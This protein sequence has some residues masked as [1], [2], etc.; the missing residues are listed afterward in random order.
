LS[1][2]LAE[3][4]MNRRFGLFLVL[5]L[6]VLSVT[7]TACLG[8]LPQ[9][10]AP[11]PEKAAGAV[12]TAPVITPTQ[13]VTATKQLTPTIAAGKATTVTTASVVSATVGVTTTARVTATTSVTVTTSMTA[14]PVSPAKPSAPVTDIMPLKLQDITFLLETYGKPANPVK[15]LPETRI[16][17]R[18]GADGKVVGKAG[19]NNYNA[20][21]V[22]TGAELS[23]GP[24]AA[25]RMICTK[26]VMLQEQAYLDALVAARTYQISSG[27]KL[28]IAYAEGGVL[29]FGVQAAAAN[30]PTISV[31]ATQAVTATGAISVT[32]QATPRAMPQP[33]RIEFPKGA[34]SDK[35]E[36]Y[37]EPGT[38]IL[39]VLRAAAGQTMTVAPTAAKGSVQVSILGADRKPLGTV[40][41]PQKWSGILPASQD[42]YLTV[43]V[44][45][46]GAATNY[47]LAI[48][49]VG[50]PGAPTSPENEPTA[51][52]FD[53]G[54][55]TT[56][57]SGQVKPGGS[58]NYTLD[59]KA[60]QKLIVGVNAN[61]P[62]RVAI[63]DPQGQLVGVA[64]A[65]A[66][67]SGVLP[68]TGEYRLVVQAPM[69]IAMVSYTLE[70]TLK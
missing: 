10:P 21:Y 29:T 1:E 67:W 35:I 61:G 11:A 17:A 68:V 70:I 20:T 66:P 7:L 47:T 53:V 62:M 58:V 42:Y 23:V 55:T 50:K 38:P 19:C 51:I 43:S 22:A 56:Q 49:I 15:V 54:A 41:S 31:T 65:K 4:F 52:R 6:L 2:T 16:T 30:A 28:S 27:G 46:G 39:Y 8:G 45:K 33:I 60:G 9:Q 25:T 44:P 18:F 3:D 48:T 36:G 63:T 59:A 64:E 32:A 24:V 69:D 5:T 37:V 14:T 12:A 34:T 26:P 57:V 13:A 40:T